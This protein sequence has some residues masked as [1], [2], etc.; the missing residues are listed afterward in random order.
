V[1]KDTDQQVN[2]PLTNA[3]FRETVGLEHIK[4]VRETD[5]KIKEGRCV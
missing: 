4:A 3:E 2:E 5:K 1:S